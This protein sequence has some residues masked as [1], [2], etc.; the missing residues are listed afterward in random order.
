MTY[1]SGF[2]LSFGVSLAVLALVAALLLRMSNLALA[3]KLTL[4]V[5]MTA[6]ACY[7]P[8]AVKGLLGLPVPA[9]LAGLPPQARLVAFVPHDEDKTADL[10]LLAGDVPR[11]FHVPLDAEMKKVLR[12]AQQEMGEGRQAYL[13]RKVS[14]KHDGK[15]NGSV[16]EAGNDEPIQYELAPG[17]GS[18]PAKD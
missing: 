12:Q 9:T 7:T 13:R 3:W 2:V 17:L 15:S 6:L 14:G 11:A 16:I 4:P 8:F 1:F 5:L 10:W 18:L